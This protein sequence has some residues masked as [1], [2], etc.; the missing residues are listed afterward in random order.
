MV[1]NII[2][3]IIIII[4]MSLAPIIYVHMVATDYHSSK[5]IARLRVYGEVVVPSSSLPRIEEFDLLS[6]KYGGQAI[7]CSNKVLYD[8]GK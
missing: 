6:V 5:G 7:A 2:I 4:T 8:N 1:V 3:I